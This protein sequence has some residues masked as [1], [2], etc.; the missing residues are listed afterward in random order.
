MT[1]ERP[2]DQRVTIGGE[3]YTIQRF[4]GLKA[5]LVI[6]SLTRM[7]RD[8]PDIIADVTKQYQK[9]NTLSVTE[10]MAKLPRWQ[11]SYTTDDFDKAERMTGERVIELPLPMTGREQLLAALPQLLESTGRR[12]VIRLFGILITPNSELAAADKESNVEVV[13]DKYSDLFLYD[14]EIDELVEV[15]LAARVAVS[16]LDERQQKRLGELIR[17]A[18]GVIN[19]AWAKMLESLPDPE[20]TPATST[21][22]APTSPTGSE[23]PT[24]G[25]DTRLS[26]ASPGVN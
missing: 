18:V 17:G 19:P 24:D 26:T 8:I 9:K 16:Q 4:R 21:P 11:G 15:A 2:V 3:E 5:I 13:L 22:D 23:S 12:E 14:A 20:L 7:G 6:A 10:A 1:K 25:L